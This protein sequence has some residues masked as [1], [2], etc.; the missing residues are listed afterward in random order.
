MKNRFAGLKEVNTLQKRGT[1]TKTT[2]T[3]QKAGK[4][5]ETL[6]QTSISNIIETPRRGRP[7]GKR[8]N[9]NFR[10]V[11]AYINKEAYKRT[12]QILRDREQQDFSELVDELLANWLRKQS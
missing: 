12:Q 4:A 2:K 6:N 8:S 1:I 7:N 3:E 9:E 10:Q 5:Q 11:T